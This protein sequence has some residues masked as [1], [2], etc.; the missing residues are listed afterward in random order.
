VIAEALREQI[1]TGQLKPGDQLPTIAELAADNT[2]AV[3]TAH[4]ALT[5]LREEGLVLV[6]RG[7]RAVVAPVGAVGA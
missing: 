7:R 1:R 3:G 4:R 5:L 6:A 2:V